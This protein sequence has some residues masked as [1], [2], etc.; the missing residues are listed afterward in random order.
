M[1]RGTG[2]ADRVTIAILYVRGIFVLLTVRNS[3]DRRVGAGE[4]SGE[5][6]A[7][8]SGG[9]ITSTLAVVGLNL[10]RLDLNLNSR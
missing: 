7:V 1:D 4:N 6:L 9:A 10:I 2:N 3:R 8:K 5:G